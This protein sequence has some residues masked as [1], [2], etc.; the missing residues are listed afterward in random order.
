MILC[1]LILMF[2]W[3]GERGVKNGRRGMWKVMSLQSVILLL[4]LQSMVLLL[5]L[6]SMVLSLLP[7][8]RVA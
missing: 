7:V 6:Q 1:H 2:L 5:S 4:S 3:G 8:G